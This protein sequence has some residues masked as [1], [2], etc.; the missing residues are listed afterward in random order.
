V[1][2]FLNIFLFNHEGLRHSYNIYETTVSII[3]TN[4]DSLKLTNDLKMAVVSIA[5]YDLL[6]RQVMLKSQNYANI[7]V[8]RNS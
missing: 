4:R 7:S 2:G 1:N 3:Y 5:N 8:F 6:C